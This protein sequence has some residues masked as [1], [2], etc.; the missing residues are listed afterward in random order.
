MSASPDVPSRPPGRPRSAQSHQAILDAALALLAESGI[1]RTSVEAIAARAGVGK[2]TI[3]R[4]W[5]SKE[6]LVADALEQ[7]KPDSRMP[8]TG[9]LWR[10]V[11]TFIERA[12]TV[13]EAVT[14]QIMAL[15]IGSREHNPEFLDIYWS[16]CVAPRRGAIAERLERAKAAGEIRADI[17]ADLAMDLVI[18][19]ALYRVLLKPPPEPFGVYLRRAFETLW[20]GIK[21]RPEP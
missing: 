21:S 1:Q 10:D 19:A 4:R 15:I 5:Q 17:D 9:N 12:V 2:A 6:E 8:D 18:G 14:R 13:D 16:N 11:H 20:H 7:L 3:Y